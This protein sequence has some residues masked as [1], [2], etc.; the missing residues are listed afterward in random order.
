MF[1]YPQDELQKY[2]KQIRGSHGADVSVAAALLYLLGPKPPAVAAPKL[3]VNW[4]N[5]F[6]R[7]VRLVYYFGE[8][9][10]E[11]LTDAAITKYFDVCSAL[12]YARD[13]KDPKFFSYTTLQND[14][15]SLRRAVNEFGQECQLGWTPRFKVPTE[16][17]RRSVFLTRNDVAK[18]LWACR[19][20]VMDPTTG[21]WLVHDAPIRL[22]DKNARKNS[23][24]KK[25]KKAGK[26]GKAKKPEF[27]KVWDVEKGDWR[28]LEESFPGETYRKIY[29]DKFAKEN[30]RGLARAILIAVYSGTRHEAIMRLVWSVHPTRGRI[31]VV[32]GMIHRSGRKVPKTSKT[33]FPTSRIVPPLLAH[34]RRWFAD[35][36]NKP[37]SKIAN[38]RRRG[39]AGKKAPKVDAIIRT[40]ERVAYRSRYLSGPMTKTCEAAGL[41]PDVVMH[42]LRHTAATWHAIMGTDMHQ[43]ARLLGMSVMT[44][45][46]IY[47]HWV[48][49]GHEAAVDIWRDRQAVARLKAIDVRPVDP[50]DVPLRLDHEPKQQRP[51]KVAQAPRIAR[52]LERR[53][54]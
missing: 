26:S 27:A 46:L 2:M 31:D 7:V 5:T 52:A 33:A 8:H 18:L 10:C 30:R 21:R 41:S 29:V 51:R 17:V 15:L 40:K 22:E 1:E 28:V 24:A 12:S 36:K 39:R 4:W 32:E 11:R 19:G 34:A 43:A 14:C 38:D 45:D 25:G 49:K 9:T 54:A 48:P 44:L 47:T 37:P 23:T 6:H 50:D 13:E 20:R 42:A 53:A 3:Q 16:R 35:D